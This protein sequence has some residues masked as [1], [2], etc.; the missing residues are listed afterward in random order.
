M[1]GVFVSAAVLLPAGV[2]RVPRQGALRMPADHG[3]HGEHDGHDGAWTTVAARVAVG[4]DGAAHPARHSLDLHRR[5]H[6]SARCST[7]T[8]SARRS[9]PTAT[10]AALQ[11]E[12]HGAWAMMAARVHH[13]AVLA[14]A[15]RRRRSPVPLHRA[16]RPARRD[17]AGAGR[18]PH[19][20][21]AQVRLRRVQRLV[22][23]RRRAPARHGPL[24][25]GAT[26]P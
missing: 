25:C 18:D 24:D 7:A 21:R 5:A 17:Q 15:R 4:R 3:E 14:G 11:G 26:R 23:R 2:L 22:L 1:A 13:A 19:D 9:P 6:R 16:P 10:M 12:F 20:P 8:G